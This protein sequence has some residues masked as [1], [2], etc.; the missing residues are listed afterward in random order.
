M[1]VFAGGTLRPGTADEVDRHA[2]RPEADAAELAEGTLAAA[3]LAGGAAPNSYH[4]QVV[5]R[6]SAPLTASVRAADGVIEAVEAPRDAHP[7][8]LG[9]QWHPELLGD[10]RP[11]RALAD[12]PR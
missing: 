6:V 1:A 2:E 9:L 10:G 7:F 11:F 12:P 8:W 3:V 4:R 5:D